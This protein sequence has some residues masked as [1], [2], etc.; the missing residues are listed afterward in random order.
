MH[1]II[2]HLSWQLQN[3]ALFE[4][5]FFPY[6][7][8]TGSIIKRNFM[9][10]LLL[11]DALA[12]QALGRR[13]VFRECAD[14]LSETD[15]WLLSHF[16]L[17][18]AVLLN[19][20]DLLEPQP[21]REMRQSNPIPHLQIL[22]V[23]GFLATGTFEREIGD[24]SGV[25]QSSVTRALPSVIKGLI[26]LSPMYIRFPYNSVDLLQIKRGLPRHSELSSGVEFS[27]P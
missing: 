21:T 19:I 18:Q 6:K 2:S 8:T 11:L 7:R 17:P 1:Y 4:E 10:Y 15:E 24:R 22:S 3:G 25:S 14:I 23:I 20:C 9:A 5:C 13:H 26:G 12:H 27:L 16:R